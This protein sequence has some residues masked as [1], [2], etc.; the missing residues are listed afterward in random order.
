[1]S[2]TIE[3]S[4]GS[5]ALFKAT[6]NSASLPTIAATTTISAGKTWVAHGVCKLVETAAYS[7]TG[8][9]CAT[10]IGSA[11]NIGRFAAEGGVDSGTSGGA[12]SG[13]AFSHH[14]AIACAHYCARYSISYTHLTLPT[15]LLV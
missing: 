2:G 4:S 13:F 5:G 11:T 6:I 1:M 12:D 8:G 7:T 15:I 10:A 3:G 14:Y 9:H